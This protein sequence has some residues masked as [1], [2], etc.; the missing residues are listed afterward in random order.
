MDPFKQTLSS[1]QQPQQQATPQVLG[2]WSPTLFVPLPPVVS[3]R[4]NGEHSASVLL[5]GPSLSTSSTIA[6][7]G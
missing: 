3:R 1:L 6:S 7:P 2:K 5:L 4:R